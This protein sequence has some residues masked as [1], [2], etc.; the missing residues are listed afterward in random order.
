MICC[1]KGSRDKEGCFYCAM[2]NDELED[3]YVTKE[4]ELTEYD[5]THGGVEVVVNR[6]E[7]ERDELMDEMD[8][9]WF[10]LE[11]MPNGG[12]MNYTHRQKGMLIIAMKKEILP[13]E[14]V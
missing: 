4:W 8:Q 7:P 6:S 5:E 13:E 10:H 2:T 11:P 1:Y 3:L 12:R 14:G 9:I